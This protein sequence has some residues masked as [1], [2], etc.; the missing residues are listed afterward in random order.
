MTTPIRPTCLRSALLSGLL[1]AVAFLNASCASAITPIYE[2]KEG[3]LPSIRFMLPGEIPLELVTLPAGSIAMEVNRKPAANETVDKDGRVVYKFKENELAVGKFEVTQA[4]WQAVM[5]TTQ[6]ELSEAARPGGR[7]FGIG[8]DLPVYDISA[9]QAKEF[10]ARLNKSLPSSFRYRF[11]L[12]DEAEW[13]Y[14][15]RAG[16]TTEL[17]NGREL[18]ARNNV[19]MAL[20]EIAWY[21]GNSFISAP[22]ASAKGLKAPNAWG[23]YDMHGNVQ[24]L[25]LDWFMRDFTAAYKGDLCAMR[26]GS[27][28]CSPEDC[29]VTACRPVDAAVPVFDAGFRLALKP[30]ANI[31]K[32]PTQ[33][34]Q[35]PLHQ[36]H[37]TGLVVLVKFPD[38]PEN[39]IIPKE[40]V[41]FFLNEKN[42]RGYGNS[43]SIHDFVDNQSYGRC[44]LKYLV[45]DYV[46]ADHNG[47]R[48]RLLP[49]GAEL[50]RRGHAHQGGDGEAPEGLRPLDRL[51]GARRHDPVRL[52]ALLAQQ[53]LRRPLAAGA[54]VHADGPDPAA[55]RASQHAGAD[56][57]HP[58]QP[59]GQHPDP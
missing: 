34:A 3:A 18:R 29:T 41:E 27:W 44:N 49:E 13:E 40:K 38:D 57:R 39:V 16:T 35:T 2:Q 15:C 55:R 23:L 21:R 36:D 50:P 12:P 4:Q 14:A 56:L 46:V 54:L 42:Y 10:C 58:G 20:G 45:S 6:K 17:N 26:G 32:T 28:H 31:P 25:C 37:I 19:S 24:E 52:R 33:Y 59:H 5:R 1:C 9:E 30:A 7:D 43:C 47:S 11:T 48:T 53:L 22:S 51:A 8:P